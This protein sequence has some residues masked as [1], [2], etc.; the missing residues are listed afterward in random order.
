MCI[1]DSSGR[2]QG[3]ELA[4]RGGAVIATD[5]ETS[6]TSYQ[7]FSI[8]DVRVARQVYRYGQESE[9]YP[10]I[11]YD[12][13]IRR[14]SYYYYSTVIYP[15]IALTLLSCTV[16]GDETIAVLPSSAPQHRPSSL[17]IVGSDRSRQSVSSS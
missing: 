7:Q 12:I 17:M 14:A 5:E 10:V 16:V 3:I 4:Q 13:V 2:H 8:K 15:C 9:P 11:I 1:R 6:G